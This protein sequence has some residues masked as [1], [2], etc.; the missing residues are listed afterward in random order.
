MAGLMESVKDCETDV[1]FEG[2]LINHHLRDRRTKASR[3]E[4]TSLDTSWALTDPR[5]NIQ[6]DVGLSRCGR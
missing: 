4:C 1:G 2:R 6:R 5:A 3:E